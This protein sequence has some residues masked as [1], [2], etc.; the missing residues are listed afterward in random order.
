MVD[1]THYSGPILETATLKWQLLTGHY[2]DTENEQ[3]Q[4]NTAVTR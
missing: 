3:H 1:Q 4:I 2:N